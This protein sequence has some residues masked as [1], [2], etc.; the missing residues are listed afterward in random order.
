[1]KPITIIFK[2]SILLSLLIAVLSIFAASMIVVLAW[3][4]LIKLLLISAIL[5]ASSFSLAK[6]GRRIL[7]WSAIALNININHELQLTRR[8]GTILSNLIIHKES[9]ATEYLVILRYHAAN[10][11]WWE[12]ALISSIVVLPDMLN[13]DDFRRLR[14]WLRWG[15]HSSNMAVKV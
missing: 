7:P 11:I 2:P 9:V 3:N 14:V 5:I 8:D 10:D 1:M 12:R 6:D 4:W 13:P 15:K